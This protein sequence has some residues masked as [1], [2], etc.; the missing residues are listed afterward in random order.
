M[1]DKQKN[2]RI[3]SPVG[4]AI[5]PHLNRPDTRFD[6]DG[7]Y[8]VKLALDG[9][10]EECTR[11]IKK[12]EEIRNAYAKGAKGAAKNYSLSDVA[13][14][15][16]TEEGV[17]TGRKIIKF[18][19]RAVVHT[20]DGPLTFSVALKDRF[21]KDITETVWGGSQIR[22]SAEVAPYAMASAKT[23]GLSLRLR[24]VQVLELVTGGDSDFGFDYETAA[25]DGEWEEAR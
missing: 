4:E 8:T 22:C 6:D 16:Y 20:E 19:Q 17:P 3:V 7:V 9:E 5:Y 1:S 15:E 2:E 24:A 11:F 25:D 21:G 23:I 10:S 14:D 12:L 18:K 13:E